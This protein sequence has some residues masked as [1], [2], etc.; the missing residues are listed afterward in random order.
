MDNEG[1]E[2]VRSTDTDGKFLDI[3]KHAD[4]DL[5]EVIDAKERIVALRQ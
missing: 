4:D 1:N 3:W 2:D 5:P